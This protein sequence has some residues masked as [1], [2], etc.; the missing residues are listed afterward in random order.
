VII[1]KINLGRVHSKGKA[2][3]HCFIVLKGQLRV[4]GAGYCLNAVCFN[5]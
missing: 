4:D 2:E 3:K 5:I 1:Y